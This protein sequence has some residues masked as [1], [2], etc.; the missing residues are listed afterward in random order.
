MTPLFKKDTHFRCDHCLE[1]LNI[2]KM[3]KHSELKDD[4]DR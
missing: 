1:Y 3:K 2:D 4:H